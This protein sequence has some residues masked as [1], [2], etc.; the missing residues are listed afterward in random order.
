MA[1]RQRKSSETDTLTPADSILR[2]SACRSLQSAWED[3]NTGVITLTVHRDTN[4]S[5][6]TFCLRL[7]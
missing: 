6:L 3:W 5:E 7:I 4:K 1:T 2:W